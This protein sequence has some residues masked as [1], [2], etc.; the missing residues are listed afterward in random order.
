MRP[1]PTRERRSKLEQAQ[2]LTEIIG[3]QKKLKIT[4]DEFESYR[5][6]LLGGSRSKSQTTDPVPLNE[7]GPNGHKIGYTREGDKVEWL[8]DD[9]KPGELWPM[10]LRRGD[11]S[12]L[13]AE[14]EFF[15]RIWY[16]RKLVLIA[17]VKEGKETID[18]EIEKGMLRAM[19][20]VEKRY[21]GKKALRSYYSNDFEWGMLNGKLSALRWVMG[22]EWDMLDT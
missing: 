6:L 12:I 4:P 13:A 21:G 16:D 7:L 10:I 17:N 18:P 15:D 22:D 11:S 8:P 3:L 19:R 2:Q 1:K 9:E 20:A 5:E 14:Q